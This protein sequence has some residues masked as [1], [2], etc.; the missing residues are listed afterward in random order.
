MFFVVS[1]KI[2]FVEKDSRHV[3]FMRHLIKKTLRKQGAENGRGGARRSEK[4]AD[5]RSRAVSYI[6]ASRDYIELLLRAR[7]RK[8][9]RASQN[10][11][12]RKERKRIQGNNCQKVWVN[13]R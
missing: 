11:N 1:R 8:K 6:S 2:L 12:E 5:R 10:P 3:P 4:A 13:V 7:K 9:M